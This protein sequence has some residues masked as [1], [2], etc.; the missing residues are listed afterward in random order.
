M[1]C[2]RKQDDPANGLAVV[3]MEQAGSM[4]D[5]GDWDRGS[6]VSISADSRTGSEANRRDRRTLTLD[7]SPS[8]APP[9]SPPPPAPPAPLPTTRPPSTATK[10]AC[11][12]AASATGRC[13]LQQSL[14]T[15]PSGRRGPSRHLRWQPCPTG[16]TRPRCG[17]RPPCGMRRLPS[18]RSHHNRGHLH[19]QHLKHLQL[20]PFERQHRIQNPRRPKQRRPSP[21]PS[22]SPHHL[23]PPF[24]Q[25]QL[26]RL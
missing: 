7:R 15:R 22:P 17:S 1:I 19:L 3:M 9:P 23:H 4:L 16:P 25:P 6:V 20:P 11:P 18:C 10:T 13:C 12:T 2:R 14:S 24:S 21:C 26:H 8:G 5:P